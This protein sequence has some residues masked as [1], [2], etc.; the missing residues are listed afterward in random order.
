VAFCIAVVGVGWAGTRQIE[1]VAELDGEVEVVALVDPDLEHARG[2]A[3]RFAIGSIHSD[4]R[5]ILTDD[6]IDAVS[7]C[8]PHDSHRDIAVAAAEAGRHVLCEKP[9]ALT[10][11]DGL[12]M[13]EVAERNGITLFV[14]ENECYTA[15]ARFLKAGVSEVVGEILHISVRSGFRNP[16]F[17]YVG[18]RSWLTQPERGG[19]DTWMLQG[20][21]TI[22]QIRFAF[23]EIKQVFMSPHSGDSFRRGDLAASMTGT[24]V[25]E[26]GVAIN[27][28]QTSEIDF[29]DLR[30]YDIYGSEGSIAVNSRGYR[31]TDSET[32]EVV[33]FPSDGLSSYAREIQAFVANV[34]GEQSGPTTGRGE[35]RTLAVVQAGYESARNGSVVSLAG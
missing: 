24:L 7:I 8:T 31:R 15:L 9:L 11:Q 10:I 35:L 14:A 29:G 2:I 18:R 3:D 20:V 5:S 6:T 1:A 28:I 13:N 22:A 27:L 32:S 12:H 26:D 23:G 33:L 4:Y 17:G 21:H 30:T 16:D 25:L 19:T 34:R